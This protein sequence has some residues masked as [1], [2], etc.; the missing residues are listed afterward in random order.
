[1]VCVLLLAPVV[2]GAACGRGSPRSAAA[3]TSTEPSKS[4]GPTPSTPLTAPKVSFAQDST[5]FA[6]V[7]EADPGLVAYEQKEG[8]MAPVPS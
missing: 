1:M 4:R 5:Y 7:T 2:G 8:N 6:E 3:T